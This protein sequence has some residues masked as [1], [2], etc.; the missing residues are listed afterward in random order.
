[1]PVGMR[2]ESGICSIQRLHN[3]QFS[4][5]GNTTCLCFMCLRVTLSLLPSRLHPSSLLPLY[6]DLLTPLSHMLPSPDSYCSF[7]TEVLDSMAQVLGLTCPGLRFDGRQRREVGW[8]P[9]E[10]PLSPP[11]P[12]L[13]SPLLQLMPPSSSAVTPPQSSARSSSPPPPPLPPGRASDRAAVPAPLLSCTG[14]KSQRGQ[15]LDSTGCDG[16]IRGDRRELSPSQ[17]DKEA[18]ATEYSNQNVGISLGTAA[19]APAA[20]EAPPAGQEVPV[21]GA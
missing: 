17:H 9:T 16:G 20:A 18:A 4:T 14:M 13:P 19:R 8:A 6:L 21:R 15:N 5:V 1:M 12:M 10:L 3:L 7:L 2:P 11:P